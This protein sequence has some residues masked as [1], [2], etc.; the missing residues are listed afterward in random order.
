MKKP[1]SDLQFKDIQGLA[2][3]GFGRLPYA[4][5]LC[6]G[7]AEKPLFRRWLKGLLERGEIASGKVHNTELGDS[8]RGIAFTAA[9]LQ[10]LMESAWLETSFPVEFTEGMVQPQRSR[11]LGDI[12]WN[13]PKAWRWGVQ[14]DIH[15]VLMCFAQQ[16]AEVEQMLD[17]A[18]QASNGLREVTR[19]YAQLPEDGKEPFGFADGISQP[20]IEGT[21]RDQA[22]VSKRER[23]LHAIAAGEFILGYPDGSGQL[24]RSPACSPA[25]PGS[26]RLAP[27]CLRPEL[28]DF[29]RNG[30]F[31]VIRQ[32]AQDVEAFKA[33]VEAHSREG[34]D[35]GEKMLGRTREGDSL[36]LDASAQ[37]VNDFDYLEDRKGQGCPIG[38]HVRRSNPRSTVH[39]RSDEAALKV[40]NRHRILRRGRVYENADGEV[41]LLFLCLNASISRQFEFIQASWSNDP[42]FQG[43]AGEV[44]P[45]SGTARGNAGVFTI[46]ASPYRHKLQS[47]P[48]WVT[49]KGGAY[50]FLPGMQ[51][52]CA[53][54]E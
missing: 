2:I 38:A 16:R 9:G 8:N 26:D 10:T 33:Y 49:L 22:L 29:G 5:Y 25:M 40:S 18:L 31:L 30:S 45:I 46:P 17:D 12:D 4:G 34:L 35:V 6:F 50:F 23:Q 19:I 32:L 36:T 52:L 7:I 28:R 37:G 42:F 51:A 24:P 41:G 20:V 21:Y 54:A 14:D 13:A 43:L 48:Q 44:D 53:L 3:R 27:H 39:D 11:L 1:G 15:G 47:V